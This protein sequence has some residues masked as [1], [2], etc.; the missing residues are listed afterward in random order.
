MIGLVWRNDQL[1][2]AEV[3]DDRGRVKGL[4]PLGGSIEFGEMRHIALQREFE[5]ELGCGVTI[6]GPWHSFENIY[7]HEGAV[8]HEFVFA[9]NV[10]LSDEQLYCRDTIRFVEKNLIA[11]QAGW[12]TPTSLPPGMH[13][14][15]TGLLSLIKAG[16]VSASG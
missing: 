16:T 6:T 11:C 9:A 1:L 2:L 15:P 4:R 13:L 7:E 10:R 8:G 14:Y 12:F 3:E 5:E